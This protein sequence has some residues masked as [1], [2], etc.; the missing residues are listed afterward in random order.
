MS[1]FLT[2][3]K[4]PVIQKLF[5]IINEH[6]YVEPTGQEDVAE[7][8]AEH[9]PT[10][11]LP[12]LDESDVDVDDYELAEQLGASS[13]A[14]FESD[15]QGADSWE[16][17]STSQSLHTGLTEDFGKLFA[18]EEGAEATCPEIK[19]EMEVSPS[20][21]K[22]AGDIKTEEAALADQANI[23]K[24]DGVAG[25]EAVTVISDSPSPTPKKMKGWTETENNKR[26]RVEFLR[27]YF[28][29]KYS[30]IWDV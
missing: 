28:G 23:T 27:P 26:E 29:I 3:P 20:L 1:L 6:Y 11:A 19:D 13:S 15:S 2:F 22:P 25:A 17:A 14:V 10:H 8:N 21:V 18:T 9:E 4:D 30:G 12:E 16:R 5:D 24:A 7:E